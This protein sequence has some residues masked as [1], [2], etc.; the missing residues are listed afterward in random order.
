MKR[1]WKTCKK[2][3][4]FSVVAV[5]YGMPVFACGKENPSTW[6]TADWVR[7]DHKRIWENMDTP[8]EN[9]FFTRDNG[10]KEDIE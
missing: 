3:A 7:K 4:H 2:C 1:D 6:V 8:S 9:C 10:K 5:L